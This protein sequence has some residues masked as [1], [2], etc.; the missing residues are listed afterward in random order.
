[1]PFKS[2]NSSRPWIL[3][4]LGTFMFFFQFGAADAVVPSVCA[5]DVVHQLQAKCKKQTE[6]ASVPEHAISFLL[7]N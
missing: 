1:M 6:H 3:L 4:E 5:A 2:I 7:L